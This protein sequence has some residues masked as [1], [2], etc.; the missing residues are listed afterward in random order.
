MRVPR[1]RKPLLA[2]RRV[3]TAIVL[4]R[5]SMSI[6]PR[7]QTTPS[8]SSPPKGSRFQPSGLTGT[9]SVWPIRSR[10]GALGSEPSMRAMR[11]SRPGSEV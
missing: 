2:S 6:A 5:F 1:G 3:A 10:R 9:T 8:T 11:L 4:V 7:P